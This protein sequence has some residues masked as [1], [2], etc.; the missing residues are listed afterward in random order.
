MQFTHALDITLTSTARVLIRM[1]IRNPKF[2]AE[3]V[4]MYFSHLIVDRK[5]KIG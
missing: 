5:R 1:S 2:M 4:Q 3:F